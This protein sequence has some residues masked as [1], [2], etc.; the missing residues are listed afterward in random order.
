MTTVNSAS[1]CELFCDSLEFE[2][3]VA[4]TAFI[5]LYTQAYL[6][7]LEPAVVELMFAAFQHGLSVASTPATLVPAVPLPFSLKTLQEHMH[8]LIGMSAEDVFKH[9]FM[10]YSDS[11]CTYPKT[12]CEYLPEKGPEMR[13]VME[14]L[15]E[16]YPDLAPAINATSWGL[17]SR[18]F[19]DEK[20]T[21]HTA[22]IP[23]V[24][25]ASRVA[26][27]SGP[28]KH[29]FHE[30]AKRFVMQFYAADEVHSGKFEELIPACAAPVAESL[31]AKMAKAVAAE[32]TAAALRQAADAALAET[33]STENLTMVKDFFK[34]SWDYFCSR[35]ASG[36]PPIRT[37][38][39]RPRHD[40]KLSNFYDLGV[41]LETYRWHLPKT[42]LWADGGVGIWQPAHPYHAVWVEFASLCSENGLAPVWAYEHD[43]MGVDCWWTLTVEP[44]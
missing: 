13:R 23:C 40:L 19:N 4:R 21:E 26:S 28:A 1:K 24:S 15:R 37:S 14:N 7:K 2:K 8:Q 25:S 38:I 10:L 41:L 31:G 20:L 34:K 18:A 44:V 30:I 11:I 32:K 36:N 33:E 17:S 35:I 27:L 42:E 43:G 39:G 3:A 9:A 22:I 16:V 6:D 12:G 29:V 5:R